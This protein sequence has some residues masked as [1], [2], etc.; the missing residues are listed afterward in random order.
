[1]SKRLA[2]AEA[3]QRRYDVRK[4][5]AERFEKALD[6]GISKAEAARQLGTTKP[7]IERALQLKKGGRGG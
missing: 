5:L 6:R 3:S 1:M 7:R 2:L 4:H